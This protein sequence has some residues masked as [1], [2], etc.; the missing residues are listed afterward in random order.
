MSASGESA[1]EL[2]T[3]PPVEVG[4]D[5]HLSIMP[6]HGGRRT[7][8]D[9][10]RLTGTPEL[11]VEIANTSYL[12]DATTKRDLYEEAGVLEYMI[13]AVP[14]GQFSVFRRSGDR[15]LTE[16]LTDGVFRS[17][18]FPGLHIDCE[19]LVDA[20]LRRARATLEAGLATPEHA[21]FVAELAARREGR[22]ES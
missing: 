12:R 19:A 14:L 18:V 6:E 2:T 10:G 16:Q 20:D 11:I 17:T 3:N 4:P 9:D 8:D 5:A 1:V 15:L 13:H 7:R 22:S 21:A